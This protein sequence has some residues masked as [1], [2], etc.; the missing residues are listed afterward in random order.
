MKETICNLLYRVLKRFPFLESR[1]AFISK[2]PPGGK[3]LDIGCGSGEVLRR[4]L[5]VRPD[6]KI[7]GIDRQDFS[8]EVPT[9]VVFNEL[10][11]RTDSIPYP[12]D[13]FDGVTMIQLIEHLDNSER[14][15]REVFRVLKPG[16]RFYIE[17]P[18][19]KSLSFPSMVFL[20]D[21]GDGP[22]N[23]HDDPT[24]VKLYRKK[25]LLALLRPFHPGEI[26][27]GNY[28]NYMY[29]LISPF[30]IIFGFLLFKRRWMVVGVHNLFGWSIYCRC[31]KGAA[32]D[33]SIA[34]PGKRR[35]ATLI[36]TII[37]AG[38]RIFTFLK[39][40]TDSPD[41]LSDLRPRNILVI[42]VD[43]IGDL[44]IST[45]VYKAL[46]ERYPEAKI[47]VLVGPWAAELLQHNPFV[48]R[49]ITLDCPWWS[50]ARR[51]VPANIGT[52]ILNYLKL[53]P[54]LRSQR[55]DL[56]IDLRADF[57]HIFLFL[58]LAR[59]KYRL[60]YHRSGGEYLLTEAL[61]YE[62]FFAIHE[63]EK[64]LRLLKAL[65]ISVEPTVPQLWWGK[66]ESDMV[67]VWLREEHLGT[68]DFKVI[69]SPSARSPIRT[70]SPQK[71]GQLADWI[72]EE[73]SG[74]VIL[75]GGPE[76]RDL[77]RSIEERMRNNSINLAGKTTLLEVAALCDSCQLFIGVEGGLMHIAAATSIPVIALY[78]PMRPELTRPDRED[79]H[80]VYRAFPC[81]PCLQLECPYSTS[82]RGECM[83]A[84]S[85]Q[86]V[87]EMT[88]K[89]ISA[90]LKRAIPIRGLQNLD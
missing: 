72:I 32:E 51:S 63:M 36:N 59:I 25:D 2:I 41:L 12:D 80:V 46:K 48:D 13:Y 53:L 6:V 58:Y 56:G 31:R 86:E 75:V 60:S 74:R 83:E 77:I 11:L 16:G 27:F 81:S 42:R 28:R 64:D 49:I 17:T 7:V 43:H 40:E 30:L 23:F 21:R 22:L 55:F 82:S 85:L 37:R 89:I 14:V 33:A 87:K 4:F 57:R 68:D 62:G 8:H 73:F 90:R 3:L 65:N 15:L 76:E 5:A 79:F 1:I 66:E 50:S 39:K 26:S 78:G 18:D 47:T 54:V 70:W 71:F 38:Y 69:I 35:M 44:M 52:F 9:G 84:I 10:D 61:P 88:G 45:P 34:N 29:A 24:H 19:E 20:P 67:A